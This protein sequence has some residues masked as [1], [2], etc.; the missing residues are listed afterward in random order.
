MEIKLNILEIE[1]KYYFHSTQL[2]WRKYLFQLRINDQSW[3]ELA[4]TTCWFRRHVHATKHGHQQQQQQQPEQVR[5]RQ[6]L[7]L[8]HCVSDNNGFIVVIAF[9]HINTLCKPITY[10]FICFSYGDSYITTDYYPTSDDSFPSTPETDR[11]V[12]VWFVTKLRQ[13]LLFLFL[14]SITVFGRV[15]D[16]WDKQFVYSI[17]CSEVESFPTSANTTTIDEVG[18]STEDGFSN[19]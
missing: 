16:V 12:I 7:M 5:V 18:S 19:R 1:S 17:H 3:W 10:Y 8:D 15:C 14:I 6:L 11:F 4:A 9:M 13:L 2:L